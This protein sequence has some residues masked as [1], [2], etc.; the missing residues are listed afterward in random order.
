[1]K[2]KKKEKKSSRP[3]NGIGDCL[4]LQSQGL[5]KTH[6]D[7]THT[8][9]EAQVS[10]THPSQKRETGWGYSKGYA[11]TVDYNTHANMGGEGLRNVYRPLGG[12]A[13]RS[14]GT[15][16]DGPVLPLPKALGV[17]VLFGFLET[18]PLSIALAILEL[19]VVS[20]GSLTN[21]PASVS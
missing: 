2:K 20:Q 19:T 21:P 18:G 15:E 1:M 16:Q 11:L 4:L 13:S 6:F 9:V 14:G 8:G 12:K 10:H 3:A 17:I 5:H 7:C